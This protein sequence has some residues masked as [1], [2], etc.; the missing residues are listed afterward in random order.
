MLQQKSILRIKVLSILLACV[1]SACTDLSA[2]REWSGTSLEATQ[3]NEVVATYADTPERVAVYDKGQASFWETQAKMRRAQAKALELQLSLVGDYM[4]ALYVLSADGVTDYTEN[5][6]QLTGSLNRTGLVAQSTVGAAGNLAT[7]LLNAATDSWRKGEVGRLIGEANAPLQKI[8]A[9][10]LRSIVD[11]DFRGDLADEAG[12]LDS[13]FKRLLRIGGGSETAN[14]ALN[15]WYVLRKQENAR[16][17]VAVD[18][19]LRVLNKI[20]EGHQKLYDNRNDLDAAQLVTDLFKLA[21]EIRKDV[22]EL[23]KA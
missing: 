10:E 9:G 14:A 11:K 18:A 22:L 17:V 19:Y 6:N 12:F 13:Y 8:L 15:E 20:S 4:E 16:R 2:V 7:T 21:K 23:M 1:L 3:F 5:V